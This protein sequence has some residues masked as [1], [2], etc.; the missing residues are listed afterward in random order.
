MR[1]A[2]APALMCVCVPAQGLSQTLSVG[3]EQAVVEEISVSEGASHPQFTVRGY[4]RTVI[5]GECHRD[6]FPTHLAVFQK[7]DNPSSDVRTWHFAG[8]TP[9]NQPPASGGTDGPPAADL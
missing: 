5:C 2:F 9:F 7:C 8:A 4:F 6:Q 3:F 1:V